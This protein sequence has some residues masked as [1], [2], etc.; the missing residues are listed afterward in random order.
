MKTRP[1]TAVLKNGLNGK[2]ALVEV[3]PQGGRIIFV[4]KQREVKTD[5]GKP[6]LVYDLEKDAGPHISGERKK[7]K[8]TKPPFTTSEAE[9]IKASKAEAE[10]II[11][12]KKQ[13]EKAKTEKPR[14][15]PKAE[16]S[17]IEQKVLAY[18]Q[19]L[20]HPATTNEVRDKF[21]FPLRANARAIFRKLDKL[22]YG[23]MRKDGKRWLFYVK[24]KEYPKP[25]EPES[26]K[27][28]AKAESKTAE[29]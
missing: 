10:K 7:R 20:D 3:R 9:L 29:A 12:P 23:E 4:I 17:D 2:S 24:G 13:A 18:V 11:S 25:K 22:G 27:T 6:R 8:E 16:L 26:K 5:M 19:G 21:N 14:E 15:K 1:Q 28:K